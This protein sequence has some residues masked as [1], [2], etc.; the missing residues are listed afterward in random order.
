MN[1]PSPG[2]VVAIVLIIL[3]VAVRANAATWAPYYAP[4][5]ETAFTVGTTELFDLFN[6]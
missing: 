3:S 5:I 2:C 6:R 4:P 1:R